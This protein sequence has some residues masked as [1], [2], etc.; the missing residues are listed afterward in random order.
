MPKTKNTKRVRFAKLRKRRITRKLRRKRQRPW[1]R[2]C[3]WRNLPITRRSGGGLRPADMSNAYNGIRGVIPVVGKSAMYSPESGSG[4]YYGYNTNPFFPD[5]VA[6]NDYFSR[7]GGALTD[8][9]RTAMHSV[10]KFYS[11]LTTQPISPSPNVMDQP[12]GNK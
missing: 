10:Q 9:G 5:P 3:S 7:G 11:T 6:S 12:I 8:L 2:D 1:V 4:I